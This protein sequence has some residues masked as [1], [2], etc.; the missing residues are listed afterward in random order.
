MHNANASDFYLR[1]VVV[2]DVNSSG[3][4]LPTGGST[5]LFRWDEDDEAHCFAYRPLKVVR[6]INPS[7]T[8]PADTDFKPFIDAGKAGW[9]STTWDFK[10]SDINGDPKAFGEDTISLLDAIKQRGT[11]FVYAQKVLNPYTGE[12][13]F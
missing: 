13:S 9:D 1:S 10:D 8:G 4:I 6:G 7:M 11:I 12:M 3:I 2:L 5:I